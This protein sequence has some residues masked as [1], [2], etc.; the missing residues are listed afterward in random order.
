M[1]PP[2]A[3]YQNPALKVAELQSLQKGEHSQVNQFIVLTLPL[4][5][6]C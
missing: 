1:T 3:D 5:N 4:K 2:R 6:I